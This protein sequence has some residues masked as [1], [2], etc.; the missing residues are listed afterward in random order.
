[1]IQ[2][3]YFSLE[4]QQQLGVAKLPCLL[5]SH[6]A[7]G[8][9]IT[10]AIP[11]GDAVGTEIYVTKAISSHMGSSVYLAPIGYVTQP[12]SDKRHQSFVSARVQQGN[13]GISAVFMLGDT[14]REYFYC[15][16]D[17]KNGICLLHAVSNPAY[18]KCSLACR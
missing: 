16:G 14:V 18:W 8:D 10:F 13:V 15:I 4:F 1:V 12:K 9:E 3:V 7:I 11:A 6:T 5:A 2:P 17:S